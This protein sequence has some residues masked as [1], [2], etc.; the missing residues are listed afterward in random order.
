MSG[1]PSPVNAEVG[2]SETT[3][4]KFLFSSKTSELRPCSDSRSLTSRKRSSNSDLTDLDCLASES[5]KP[6]LG[7]ACHPYSLSI[8]KTSVRL[9]TLGRLYGQDWCIHLV[10]G[11][12]ERRLALLQQVERLDSL[13]L[14]ALLRGISE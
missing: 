7:V 14:E 1:I 9:N 10:Q 12:N 3:R 4:P 6:L 13:R 2:T 8:C 5:R 11:D